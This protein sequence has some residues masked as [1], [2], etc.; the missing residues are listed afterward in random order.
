MDAT[1]AIEPCA[2]ALLF[3]GLRDGQ[4]AQ[5]V[6]CF[7]QLLLLGIEHSHVRF[8]VGESVADG[9]CEFGLS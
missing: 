2:F 5:L 9:L 1:A 8:D 7:H 6:R 3:N 4:R